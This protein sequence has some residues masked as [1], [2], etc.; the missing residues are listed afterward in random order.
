MSQVTTS[1]FDELFPQ[2]MEQIQRSCFLAIDTEFSTLET[3]SSA[4][5]PSTRTLEQFYEQ[6]STLIDQLTVFQFGLAI[7]SA[8]STTHQQRYHVQ[9][10]TFYLNPTSINPIDVRYVIQSSS[11]KFLAAHN[12]DFNKCFYE[13]ISFLNQ[14]QEQ[15][16]LDATKVSLRTLAQIPVPCDV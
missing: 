3:L 4:S 8:S 7:F 2:I 6:R 16:L 1:N 14:T 10:Y 12:F 13:G 15:A 9:I 5:S 11:M